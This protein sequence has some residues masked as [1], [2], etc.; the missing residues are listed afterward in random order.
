MGV[1]CDESVLREVSEEMQLFCEV[2]PYLG[3]SR[4]EVDNIR[5]DNPSEKTRKLAVLNTWSR[6]NGSDA[7]YSRLARAFLKMKDR[8]TAE[9]VVLH[10]RNVHF[11]CHQKSQSTDVSPE[12]AVE[13]FQNWKSMSKEE[14]DGVKEELTEEND[15]I[16]KKYAFCLTKLTSRFE[17][18]S[19]DIKK[20]K[21]GLIAYMKGKASV[22]ELSSAETISDIFLELAKHTSWFN[23]CLLEFVVESINDEEG[24]AILA[25]Y[26]ENTLKPYLERSIFLIPSKSMA[27]YASKSY[28]PCV[29]MV[30]DVKDLSAKETRLIMKR[31]V[32]LLGIPSLQ[33]M[34]F[35]DG[36]VRLV[37]G[38]HQEIFEYEMH[39]ENSL[40]Q[41]YAAWNE[42]D[43]ECI[44]TVDIVT[45][46]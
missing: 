33:L 29:M 32:K 8:H 36:S 11:T 18:M 23:F 25:E 43:Q 28:V 41:K 34:S 16:Q 2:A 21:I 9:V 15:E 3:L 44:I 6:K 14:Q 38:I 1:N 35:G 7:T 39:Q 46:L 26:A 40:L 5:A 22:S 12:K 17:E 10:V 19:L 31:L 4:Q 24:N 37:F 42:K 20:L 30:D 27:T 13:Q 45:I